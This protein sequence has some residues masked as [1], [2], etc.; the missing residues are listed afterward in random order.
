MPRE[1]V[2]PIETDKG[3]DVDQWLEKWFD[4]SNYRSTRTAVFDHVGFKHN[5]DLIYKLVNIVD[6]YALAKLESFYCHTERLRN[7]VCLLEPPIDHC[8]KAAN[9]KQDDDVIM[10][11]EQRTGIAFGWDVTLDADYT[12]IQCCIYDAANITNYQQAIDNIDVALS[13]MKVHKHF[14][15]HEDELQRY[16]R[17]VYN[18][19]KMR[20]TM[21]KYISCIVSGKEYD[22]IQLETMFNTAVSRN[23]R[24]SNHGNIKSLYAFLILMPLIKRHFTTESDPWSIAPLIYKAYRNMVDNL[25]KH[26]FSK[27]VVTMGRMFGSVAKQNICRSIHSMRTNKHIENLSKYNDTVPWI[28]V[29]NFVRSKATSNGLK[30]IPMNIEKFSTIAISKTAFQDN[31]NV[32]VKLSPILG[33]NGKC[34][35]SFG[36]ENGVWLAPCSQ[37]LSCLSLDG[38]RII[39]DMPGNEYWEFPSELKHN[40]VLSFKG[41]IVDIFLSDVSKPKLKPFNAN[42]VCC[43]CLDDVQNRKIILPCR[44]QFHTDCI[45]N[46]HRINRACPI[47]KSS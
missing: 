39:V 9:V 45:H 4:Q 10:Y 34:K 7:T 12:R 21:Q 37:E 2:T 26:D 36:K 32:V 46:W 3:I 43:I 14:Y 25:P 44:H 27:C 30:I 8:E 18:T 41:V 38:N 15:D 28:E 29:N 33:S 47:C 35:L 31:M 11:N 17:V 13:V 24:H 5:G 20:D 22:N 16:T 1:L 40:I 6:D 42:D 19:P 23:M